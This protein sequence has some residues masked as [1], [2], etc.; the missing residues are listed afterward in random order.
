MHK[1]LVLLETQETRP[2]AT[3]IHVLPGTIEGVKVEMSLNLLKRRARE[4]MHEHP[5]R[6]QTLF[7][8]FSVCVINRSVSLLTWLQE[9]TALLAMMFEG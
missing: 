8:L 3:S 2:S 7:R 5:Q 9:A 4:K 1:K 6:I